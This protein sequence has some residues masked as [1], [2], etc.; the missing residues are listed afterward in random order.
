[1]VRIQLFHFYWR[2]CRAIVQELLEIAVGAGNTACWKEQ[3]V[4]RHYKCPTLRLRVEIAVP[5]TND[6]AETPVM[7]SEATGAAFVKMHLMPGRMSLREVNR[8][9]TVFRTH[10]HGRHA[11]EMGKQR[12]SSCCQDV[13]TNVSLGKVWE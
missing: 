3:L 11:L 10:W 1:M 8:A 2:A 13:Q 6:V 4:P 5:V 7:L 9:R 12:R